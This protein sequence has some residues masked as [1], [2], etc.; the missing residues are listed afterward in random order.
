MLLQYPSIFRAEQ[1]A[2]NAN[3]TCKHWRFPVCKLWL[4]FRRS[5]GPATPEIL[6]IHPSE[7]LTVIVDAV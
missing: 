2:L 1:G 7:D 3:H 6:P 5:S 4:Q